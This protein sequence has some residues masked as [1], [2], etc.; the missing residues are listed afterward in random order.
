MTQIDDF[1]AG[2]PYDSL[3]SRNAPR[4]TAFWAWSSEEWI[5]MLITKK[6]K[7]D[8]KCVSTPATDFVMSVVGMQ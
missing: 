2:E 6:R 3:C 1:I 7:A 5:E 4:K 8:R